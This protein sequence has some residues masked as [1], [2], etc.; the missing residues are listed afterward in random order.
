V[1]VERY[2]SQMQDEA[3]RMLARAFVTNPLHVAVFGP[4]QLQSNV[5]FFQSALRVLKGR[6]LVGLEGERIVALIHWVHS[7]RCQFSLLE[8]LRMVPR[9]VSGLGVPASVRVG[10]W[11][12]AWSKHDP[13]RPHTH[14]GPIGV[15]PAV[16]GR[17]IG[18]RLMDEYCHDLDRTGAA[19]YLE[20]DR[21]ENVR[22][23]RRFGF[24]MADEVEVLGVRNYLMWRAGRSHS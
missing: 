2:A 19:G 21:L 3:S 7:P 6:T 15:D 14:L 12:E 22:F 17:R 10:G 18:Q 20:T 11:L 1:R 24:V 9:L 5:A 8:K 16:Q 4:D 23:Y 13:I